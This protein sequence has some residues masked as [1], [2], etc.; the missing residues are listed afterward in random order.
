[1]TEHLGHEKHQAPTPGNGNIRNATRPKTVLTDAAGEVSLTVPRDRA[2][3]FEPVIVKRRRLRP[4]AGCVSAAR[5]A[6]RL[7]RRTRAPPLLGH[8]L[9][10]A[11]RSRPPDPASCLAW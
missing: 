9:R 2:D 4:R 10:H 1:M 11:W 7:R 3:A 8:R 5:L 6:P